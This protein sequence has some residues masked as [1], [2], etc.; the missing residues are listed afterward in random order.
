MTRLGT[1]VAVAG[2][3]V[4]AAAWQAAPS[5][6]EAGVRAALNH[7]IQGLATGDGAHFAQAFH[8]EA[9]LFWIGPD[10]QLMQRTSADFIK[11][12]AG[13][14]AADEAKRTRTI[15][16]INITGNAAV[17]KVVLDYPAVKFTDY[18]SMLKIGNEWKIVNK[19]YVAERQAQ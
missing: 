11:G 12:A 9:K 2:L 16:S 10:G 13:K 6:E 7:Y 19:T 15:E 8:P 14:P 18:M 1:F 3:C 17:A 4:T 5:R